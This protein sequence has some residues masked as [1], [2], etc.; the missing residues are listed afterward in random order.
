MYSSEPEPIHV[1]LVDDHSAIAVGVERM[2]QQIPALLLTSATTVAQLQQ[3]RSSFDLVL[4]DLRLGDRS[5]VTDNVRVLQQVTSR[6][7]IFT[8]GENRALIREAA[9]GGAI[10]LLRKTASVDTVVR[11]VRAALRDEVPESTDWAAAL[12]SDPTLADARLTRRELEILGLY[13]GGERAE[14]VAARLGI[15]HETVLDHVR[16]IRQ[17]Y[18]AVGRSAP[19][20]VDLYRRAQED[21]YLDPGR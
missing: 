3:R 18:S 20:K 7:L 2:L 21:G 9:R 12:D 10:G 1:G 6:I 16:N 8:S 15:A 14:S 17:K 19:T 13:A 11:A 4:L 5:T